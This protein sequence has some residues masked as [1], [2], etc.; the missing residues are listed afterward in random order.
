MSSPAARQ[1][2]R[3]GGGRAVA[4]IDGNSFYCSCERVFD[5][6]LARVPVIVLSNNDGCAIARTAEAKALGIRMGEPFFKIRD[7]CRTQ[8]VRVFSSNYT[9]YGDMSGRTNAVYR[10]FSPR[11]E[12]YSIDESFLD[13]SDVAPVLR[14]ELARDLRATVRAWTGIPTCV[15]IG[16]TKTLAKLANHIA[17]SVPDLNGVC[18]LT[19]VAAYEHW[20]C[21]IEAGE[22][23]GIGRASLAKLEAMGV[24]S[25]ADLRDLDPRPVR[26]GLTVVG[27]R[28]IYELRGLACLPLDLVPARRKGCAV[29]RSFSSRITDRTTLEEAVAAHATRLGEKLRRE[30]LGTDHVTVFYHTSEHDRD[31]PQ[32]SV[33]TTVTLPEHTSDSLALIKAARL[34]VAKTWR[35][36]SPDRPAWRYSKAGVVT[37]DLAPL[38]HSPRALIGALDRERS[39]PLMAAM[40]ACNARWGRGAVVPARAGLTTRRDWNTKFD[41]RTPRYTTQLGELPVAYT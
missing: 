41:M 4:L 30:G 21:R 31:A 38:S 24:E 34:G 26:K 36:P 3:I 40:D 11:V 23:W 6:K 14:V 37:N 2:D 7:L 5:P 19:D 13:L 17:K 8:G 39:G 18:D 25:V 12:I 22:V 27:E 33:A 10:Q 20:L 35:E 32:R 28:I 16:P 15:G 29:T 9:L 1:R